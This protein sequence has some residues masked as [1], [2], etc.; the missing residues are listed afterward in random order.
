M[1]NK[2]FKDGLDDNAKRFIEKFWHTDD[3]LQSYIDTHKHII[4]VRASNIL[5]NV[6]SWKY[7]GQVCQENLDD[8][9]PRQK[10]ILERIS[11]YKEREG[12][13]PFDD[14]EEYIIN[15]GLTP[16]PLTNLR[17]LIPLWWFYEFLDRNKFM[18]HI[19]SS[20]ETN[21]RRYQELDKKTWEH[22]YRRMCLDL[23]KNG[24]NSIN[25]DAILTQ[26]V[27]L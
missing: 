27:K 24:Y 15:K 23:K 7:Y 4:K 12:S 21:Y 2:T 9:T 1:R 22:S 6:K 18:G 11:E 3:S 20:I 8:C 26:D 17:K 13:C 19:Q 5:G 14:Y 10:F 25:I 16:N